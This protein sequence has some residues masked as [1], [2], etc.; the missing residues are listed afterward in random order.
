MQRSLE[1][2]Y[3][4]K[5]CAKLGQSCS[6][7]LKLLTTAY[8]DVVLSSSQ[9]FRWHKAITEGGKSIKDEQRAECTEQIGDSHIPISLLRIYYP[10]NWGSGSSFSKLQNFVGGRFEPTTT[11]LGTSLQDTVNVDRLLCKI[12]VIVVSDK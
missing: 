2:G 11:P 3:A 12:P 10:W 4:I 9:I 6:E 5:V 8:R 7:N 1:Q